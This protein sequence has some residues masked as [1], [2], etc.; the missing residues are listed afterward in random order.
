MTPLMKPILISLLM[1]GETVV[2]TKSQVEFG[3]GEEWG[4]ARRTQETV[5]KAR[6]LS[7]SQFEKCRRDC[8]AAFCA[9]KRA[10]L[11]PICD[12]DCIKECK[13]Q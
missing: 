10:S 2:L 4:T 12:I 1:I 3:S 6:A 8:F 7:G 13:K 5:W 11:Q 9:K